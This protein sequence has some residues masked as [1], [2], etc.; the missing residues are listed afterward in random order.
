[1]HKAIND[2]CEK[3]GLKYDDHFKLLP[4]ADYSNLTHNLSLA[5]RTLS[6]D[7]LKKE[8]LM[9]KLQAMGTNPDIAQVVVTCMWVR[10]DEIRAQLVKDSCNISQAKLENFDWKLKV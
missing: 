8:Q 9:E 3:A 4:L 2:I 5:I 10:R 7:Q 6:R 1:M